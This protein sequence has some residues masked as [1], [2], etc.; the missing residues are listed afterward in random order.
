MCKVSSG[1]EWSFADKPTIDDEKVMSAPIC[2]RNMSVRQGCPL[3]ATVY[4]IVTDCI[5]RFILSRI[6][7]AS[8]L[9]AYA[10][11]IAV[12]LQDLSLIHI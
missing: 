10:D 6:P 9:R 7:R 8:C 12:V 3:S 4:V 2:T 11:D 5:I 1:I